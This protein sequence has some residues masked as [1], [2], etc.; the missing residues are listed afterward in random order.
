MHTTFI[1]M[2]KSI[3]T[4]I[5][6]LP[7]FY[8]VAKVFRGVFSMLLIALQIIAMMMRKASLPTT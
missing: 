2:Y 8:V 4:I 1:Y 7:G 6:C 3:I 5:Q